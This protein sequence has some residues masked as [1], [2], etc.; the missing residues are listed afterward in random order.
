M[1][2]SD[3]SGEP[4]D[5][6]NGPF[7]AIPYEWLAHFPALGMNAQEW[8]VVTQ[9]LA[10]SQV[11]R[12]D[13]L[14]PQELADRTGF[15]PYA[16]GEIVDGLVSRG[17]VSIGERVDDQGTQ[18]HY[19][20]LAPLWAHIRKPVPVPTDKRRKRTA[21][22]DIVS[23][24]EEEF[25][26]PLS[27]LECD[28]VRQWLELDSHPDWMLTEALREAVLA[29]KYSFKYMDRILFEWQRNRVRTRQELET[30]RTSYRERATAREEA[31]AATN[32][33]KTSRRTKPAAPAA[34]DERYS[35]FYQL[36]PDS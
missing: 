9:I 34:Q 27:G 13:F 23:L 6:L 36:F 1:K 29:N 11:T 28:Q 24:F 30:Y 20:D 26:R 14:S 3:T 21:Q 32:V 10:A 12:H 22:T 35:K 2:P 7:V 31:A 25:G 5:V 4:H 33:S 8:L 17:L 16:I 19:F 15:T 18:S